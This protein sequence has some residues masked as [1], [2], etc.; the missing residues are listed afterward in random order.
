M[1]NVLCEFSKLNINLRRKLT[2]IIEN[3]ILNFD[4]NTSFESEFVILNVYLEM[5]SSQFIEI[6]I[7]NVKR[8]T[9]FKFEFGKLISLRSIFRRKFSI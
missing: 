4:R 3:L 5:N 6:L 8:N 9:S 7:L 2:A 1:P